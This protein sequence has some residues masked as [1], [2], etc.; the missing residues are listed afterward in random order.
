MARY[1]DLQ[2]PE[3][4]AGTKYSDAFCTLIGLSMFTGDIYLSTGHKLTQ[5][6][7]RLSGKYTTQKI[8]V[9]S[10]NHKH[11]LSTG[12]HHLVLYDFDTEK[13]IMGISRRDI[14]HAIS[15]TRYSARQY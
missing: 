3:K 13:V 10:R 9:A 1:L 11:P 14:W 7:L 15:L 8:P 5:M 6:H 2:V 12:D 4:S